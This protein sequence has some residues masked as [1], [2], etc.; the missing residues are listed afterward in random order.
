MV[1]KA[2]KTE[3]ISPLAEITNEEQV[4]VLLFN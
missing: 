1:L 3:W 4:S 2:S